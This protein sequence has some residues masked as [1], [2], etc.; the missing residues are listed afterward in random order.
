MIYLVHVVD[1]SVLSSVHLLFAFSFCLSRSL[2]CF[3]L[4]HPLLFVSLYTSLYVHTFMHMH[5]YISVK[6]ISALLQPHRVISWSLVMKK[7]ENLL[8]ITMTY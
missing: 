5:I 6:M 4:S 8:T 7:L 1:N 3:S 2:L